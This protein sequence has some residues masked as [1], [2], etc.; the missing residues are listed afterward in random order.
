MATF[1][2]DF[3]IR[4]AI[5]SIMMILVWHTMNQQAQSL[6]ENQ[7]ITKMKEAADYLNSELNTV[8]ISLQKMN[9]SLNKTIS[10]PQDYNYYYKVNLSCI[11]GNIWIM[12]NTEDI[13]K[14]FI[15]KKHVKCTT[16]TV[17]GDIYPGENCIHAKRIE[18][19]FGNVYV[20]MSLEG[21]CWNLK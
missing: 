21:D 15:I 3:A 12:A 9:S 5:L 10:M 13:G 7:Q 2:I 17:S 18:D 20:N 1:S 8:M 19:I 16:D 11:D 4:I 14:T 6:K